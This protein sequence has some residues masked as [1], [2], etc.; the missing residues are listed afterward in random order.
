MVFSTRLKLIIYTLLQI[1]AANQI[2][3][4]HGQIFRGDNGSDPESDP[5]YPNFEATV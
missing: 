2:P 5:K 3:N 4:L 1:R